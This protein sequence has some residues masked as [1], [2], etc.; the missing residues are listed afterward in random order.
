[1]RGFSP[2]AVLGR[3]VGRT[4]QSKHRYPRRKN[5]L[6]EFPD[7]GKVRGKTP[8]QGGGLRKRWK[9]PKSDWSPD[10]AR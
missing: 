5:G 1:M 4:G 6:P 3:R 10:Q 9:D 2:T 8:V 7:A